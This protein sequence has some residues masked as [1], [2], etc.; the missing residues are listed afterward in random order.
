[1]D[2]TKHASAIVSFSKLAMVKNRMR[3]VLAIIALLMLPTWGAAD[4]SVPGLTLRVVAEDTPAGGTL[5]L[6]IYLAAPKSVASGGIAMDFDPAIFG[7]VATVALFSASGDGVGYARFVGGRLDAHFWSQSGSIGQLPDRPI[8][9]ISIPVLAGAATGATSALTIDPNGTVFNSCQILQCGPPWQDP[10]G[11]TYS[12][13]VLP[14]AFRV[15]GS[16]SVQSVSP[17]GGLVPAGAAV[18]I[19]GMGF[20]SSTVAQ[21]EGVGIA[22]TQFV[23]PQ[24]ISLVLGGDTELTGKRV[25][26]T[27]SAGEQ[28]DH[29]PSLP[30]LATQVVPL[31]GD[32]SP[33]HFLVPMVTDQAVQLGYEYATGP[34]YL[35][36]QNQT[37]SPVALSIVAEP[38]LEPLVTTTLVVPAGSTYAGYIKAIQLDYGGTYAIAS[39]P[40]RMEGYAGVITS[41]AYP[42]QE[43]AGSVLPLTAL[44]ADMFSA[45][46]PAAWNWQVGSPALAPQTVPVRSYGLVDFTVSVSPGAEQWLSVTPTS[47]T[48]PTALTITPNVSSLTPGTYTATVTLTPILFASLNPPLIATFQAV[49]N[50]SAAGTQTGGG[51]TPTASNPTVYT[52]PPVMASV[53][54]GASQAL[55]SLSPGEIISIFGMGI[56]GAPASFSLDAKGNLPTSLNGTQVLIDGKPAPLLYTSG[57][58][59]NAIVP[60]DVGGSGTATI[61]VAASGLES[62]TWGMPVAPTA[63]GIF[64]I[65]GGIG[66]AAAL[67]QDGSVN[68]PSNPAARGSVVTF[69]GTGCG[70]TTPAN[71]TGTVAP[72][73]AAVSV[74]PVT[75]T[76]GGA[77][78]AVAYSGSAPG[79]VAGLCQINVVAPPGIAPGP[80][81]PV[82]IA[83]GGAQSPGGVTIA[84]Q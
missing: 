37:Q 51:T 80:A 11:N 78:A 28:L 69:F 56:G 77:S 21:M 10:A 26:L 66:Q 64:T 59:I 34:E 65:G 55:A 23:S 30:S 75:A 22:S 53:V 84:V 31:D 43:S 52:P 76:I 14:G 12:V 36:L 48:A 6:K 58:Q 79:E 44:P 67:N 60:Y 54:N 33:L 62:A 39:A 24:Q 19:N 74:L 3:P 35:A 38:A 73:I 15:G 13:T 25:R 5:Q 46:A 41:L 57:N 9:A 70:Q 27:N 81:V 16:I 47:G 83:A 68:G 50:V 61:Q 40:I 49:L 18:Q 71:A 42:E 32:S 45:S 1:V 63:P 7:D 82:M 29:F 4:S 72:G 2:G 8:L 17:A 20:D